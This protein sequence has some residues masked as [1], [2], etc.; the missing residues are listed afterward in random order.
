MV[1]SSLETVF[2]ALVSTEAP[3]SVVSTW[4]LASVSD[5]TRLIAVESTATLS[6]AILPEISRDVSVF[7]VAFSAP[8]AEIF[9]PSFKSTDA[10]V[11]W[12]TTFTTAFIYEVA[13][14]ALA[15]LIVVATLDVFAASA[16]MARSPFAFTSP[17][18]VTLAAEVEPL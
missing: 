6:V 15:F 4:T 14:S 1:I 8:P 2:L 18:T 10:V 5:P 7:A 12:E 17:K 16:E 3:D 11:L 13:A 9:A